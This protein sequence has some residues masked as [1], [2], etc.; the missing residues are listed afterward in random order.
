M[1]SLLTL[2]HYSHELIRH[3]H[4]YPQ[5]VFGLRGMLQFEVSG[6]ENLVAGQMMAVV[7]DSAEHTCGSPHGSQCLVLDIPSEGWL[8]ERLGE[9]ADASRKLLDQAAIR[10]LNPSQNQLIAWLA[11]SPI[12]D[13]LIAEQG[14][15]LLLASLDTD[16]V[17]EPHTL[18]L[19]AISTFID[20]HLAHPLQVSDL[21][22]ISG[23]SS[24]R[25][26]ARFLAD[27]GMTPMEYVRERRLEHGRNLLL[28]TS[29]AVHEVATQAGY[30]SQSAFT[31]ALSRHC[32]LTPRQLREYRE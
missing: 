21:A 25:F 1:H 32:G 9:H 26:H 12:N 27:T 6:Q 8:I 17:P 3:S 30:N 28:S 22:R 20:K 10:H 29:L 24:A 14:A 11:N 18:P 23:L 5:V 19:T 4:A 16:A 13:P 31:A 2:R 15:I 7:P